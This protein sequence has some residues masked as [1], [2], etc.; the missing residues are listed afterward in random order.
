MDRETPG[1]KLGPSVLVV[2]TFTR[3]AILL[4]LVNLILLTKKLRLDRRDEP[5]PKFRTLTL[6]GT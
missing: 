1:I 2:S 5:D 3:C 4:T 6:V